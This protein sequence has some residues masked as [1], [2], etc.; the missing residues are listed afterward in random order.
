MTHSILR[1]SKLFALVALTAFAAACG[2]DDD[3]DNGGNNPPPTENRIV[4]LTGAASIFPPAAALLAQAGGGTYD[5]GDLS[6]LNVTLASALAELNPNNTTY[7]A[8]AEPLTDASGLDA[9]FSVENVD[10]DQVGIAVIAHLEPAAGATNPAQSHRVTTGI[11]FADPFL[12]GDLPATIDT[13]ENGAPAFIVPAAFE[14]AL[15]GEIGVALETLISEGYI[16]ALA[17][18]GTAP[19]PGATIT[20]RNAVTQ[21]DVT[22]DYDILYPTFSGGTGA[23]TDDTGL[24]VIRRKT[25]ATQPPEQ[26]VVTATVGATS[27][28]GQGGIKANTTFVAPVTPV[29]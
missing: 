11:L 26:L 7:L 16:L 29:P 24:A 17:T 3:D 1:W 18:T 5:P 9:Q 6:N 4:T 21:T 22:N 2:D 25:P 13:A 12:Q 19:V 23:S 28:S 14:A 8:P 15:A 10:A 27:Y 20:L